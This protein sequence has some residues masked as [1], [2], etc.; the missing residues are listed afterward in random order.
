[1]IMTDFV[2]E[3]FTNEFGQTIQPGEDVLFAGSSWKR[4][5]IRKGKF[6][7]VRYGDVF[8]TEYFK[9]AEGNYIKEEKTAWNGTKYF[10]H[11]TETKKSREVVAV[12]I[13]KVNRGKAWKWVDR[14]DG[15]RDYV[16]TDEDLF[17]T[18]IL[19][20][21]RVYKLETGLKEMEGKTF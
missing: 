7:G 8:R 21:K 20:L 4:T 14:P 10:A 9:D 12:V 6:K 2:A 18:S 16:V 1:M 11:K 17:G 15:S 3:A 13:E 5:S 19:P